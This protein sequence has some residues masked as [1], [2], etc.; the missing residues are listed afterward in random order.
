MAI[1]ETARRTRRT[2]LAGAIGGTAVLAASA[3][4]HPLVAQA[5][6]GTPVLLGE[7]NTESSGTIVENTTSSDAALAGHSTLGDGV[8]G[9][10]ASEGGRGVS[11]RSSG[12]GFGVLGEAT[13]PDGTGVYG[14]A[15]ATT[16]STVGVLGA[17]NSPDGIGVRG[18]GNATGAGNGYGVW[19]ETAAKNGIGVYGSASSATGGGFGVFGQSASSTG[20]GVYGT[21]SRFGA[22]GN[23]SGTG[24]LGHSGNKTGVL[25]F[26]GVVTMGVE[27]PPPQPKTGVFGYCDLDATAVGVLGKTTLGQGVEGLATTGTAGLFKTNGLKSGT[28]L[29]TIGRV[30]FDNSVGIATIGAGKSSVTVTPGIALTTSSAVVATLQANP[31][32]SLTVQ[33]VVVNATADTFTI[34]L[35]G[36]TSAALKV[37]WHVFG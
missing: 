33:G 10:S 20:A 9:E 15:D 12:G 11:G 7:T 5:A 34:Y 31:S 24:V 30:R 23:S 14:Y 29:R 25:G 3:L 22:W 26:S 32:G 1:D 13:G 36:N 16:G 6:A 17:V 28:A 18:I 2:V 27:P 37:A 35:T 4:G 8:E 19:G 21:G